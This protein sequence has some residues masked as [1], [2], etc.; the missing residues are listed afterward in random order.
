[1]PILAV[2]VPASL[3]GAVAVFYLARAV[4][5]RELVQVRSVL[6][7]HAY[8]CDGLG[9]EFLVSKNVRKSGAEFKIHAVTLSP[10]RGLDKL[11][12]ASA[13]RSLRVPAT[14]NSADTWS[15]RWGAPVLLPPSDSAL[16]PGGKVDDEPVIKRTGLRFA[17]AGSGSAQAIHAERAHI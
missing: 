15:M 10:R 9:S 2:T 7:Q 4:G 3:A 17:E 14:G 16:S 12:P 11:N 1:M 13:L 6:A 5:A 8:A